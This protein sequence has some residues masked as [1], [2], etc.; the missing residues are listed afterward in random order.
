MILALLIA[1]LGVPA[2]AA[3]QPLS[4]A[5]S[6][7]YLPNVTKMLGGRDGWQTPF[8]VQNV[9]ASVAQVE[10]SFY[11]FGDGSLVKTRSIPSLAAGT[12]V[13]HDPNSDADLPA[14]GQFSV[15]VQSVG[16]QIVAVVNEHQNVSNQARQ[17]AL[18]Y[19]GL[20]SGS[21]KVYLPYIAKNVGGWLTTIIIQNLGSSATTVTATFAGLAGGTT[22]ATLTRTIDPGRSQFVDPRQE[23]AL[24]DG[25]EYT[26]TL[27]ADQPVGAV[28]NAHNDAADVAAPRGFS[29]NGSPA[30]SVVD[31]WVPY[32]ARNTDGIGRTTRLFIQN[33]GTTATKP[34]LYFRRFG[35]KTAIPI[36][37]A[38]PIAPGAGFAFDP[39][40]NLLLSDSEYGLHINGGQYAVVAATLSPQT[41]MGYTATPGS[42]TRL[43]LPNVTRTL[44][45]SDGWTT[46]IILQGR[47]TTKTTSATL[48]WYR[49]SDGSLIY[50]QLVLGLGY[51]VS[52]RVDPR[53]IPQL[54]DNTQYAVVV[55]A[56]TGGVSA[57]V[58]ELNFQ[59]GDGAMIYEGFVNPPVV[60]GTT[61]CSPSGAPA[62]TTFT[63]NYYGY[64]PGTTPLTF[65]LLPPSGAPTTQTVNDVVASDGSLTFSFPIVQPGVWT[66]TLAGGGVS[67]ANSLTVGPA[68][69]PETFAAS[70]NGQV[71]V[72]TAPGI[73]CT[74]RAQQPDGTS[75][76]SGAL[77]VTQVSN[78]AGQAVWSY[79]PF[80][81][82]A[83]QWRHY[84]ACTKGSETLNY[85]QLFNVP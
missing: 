6:T 8:I 78:D 49:F 5:T 65:T 63:C 46:P 71:A 68:S 48:S 12:S 72:V 28:V 31:T 33:V 36:A 85:Y 45:G 69:F 19:G 25:N 77:S 4:G 23:A 34:N 13:F 51:G 64:P 1:S 58:T 47:D 40:S 81:A 38:G 39:A 70:S 30:T 59:G 22:P 16:S 66:V 27:S 62:G 73:A 2:R 42:Q 75:A 11:A 44:G 14:G 37:L 9:G 21:R 52:A 43:F 26:V 50:K 53:T 57:I 15:V 56:P 80:T 79:P 7:I 18:S 35:D 17:E 67:Q 32:V 3:N 83:G 41:A 74:A 24:V 60:Y 10:M 76:T 84:V 61:S 29:Y 54:A 55:E 82:P 20:G